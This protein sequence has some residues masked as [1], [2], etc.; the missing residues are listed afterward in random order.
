MNSA[1]EKPGWTDA[2]QLSCDD[3]SGDRYVQVID[4]W[5]QTAASNHEFHIIMWGQLAPL[6]SAEQTMSACS[7][8]AARSP[9]CGAVL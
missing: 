5:L 6:S 4:R 7:S 8:S 3:I 9:S 2:R 1:S